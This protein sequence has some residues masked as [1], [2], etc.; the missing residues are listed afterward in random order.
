MR[1]GEVV[2]ESGADQSPGTG[3]RIGVERVECLLEPILG[4]LAGVDG[5]G[6]MGHQPIPKKRGPNQRALVICC[7]IAESE[8]RVRPSIA[9]PRPPP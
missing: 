5:A 3:L 7:V 2:P 9:N 1:Q 8:R 6:D 4:T